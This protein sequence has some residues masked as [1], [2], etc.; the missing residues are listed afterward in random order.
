[1]EL[2]NEKVSSHYPQAG[3]LFQR[4]RHKV[5]WSAPTCKGPNCGFGDPSHAN[6][7]SYTPA[8]FCGKLAISDTWPSKSLEAGQQS[9]SL[10]KA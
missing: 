2:A 6:K 10:A 7:T 8:T 1:M 3:P 5:A 4:S 9:G